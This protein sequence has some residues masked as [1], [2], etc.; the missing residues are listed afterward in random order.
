M[1]IQ[2]MGLMDTLMGMESVETTHP[3][4]IA[5]PPLMLPGMKLPTAKLQAIRMAGLVLTM[6]TLV[7]AMVTL[8]M[9]MEA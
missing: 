5:A 6:F 9:A 7:T 2:Q 1:L 4:P 8:G 3:A